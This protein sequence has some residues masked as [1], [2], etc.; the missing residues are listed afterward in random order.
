M[1]SML[2]NSKLAVNFFSEIRWEIADKKG[3]SCMYTC[4]LDKLDLASQW[5][6]NVGLISVMNIGLDCVGYD[7]RMIDIGKCESK[8]H[9]YW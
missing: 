5:L 8:V 9:S 1:V 3:F 6:V 4:A 2:Q 7:S